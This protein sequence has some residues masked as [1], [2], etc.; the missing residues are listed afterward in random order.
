MPDFERIID[1]ARIH[2]APDDAMREWAKGY[3]AGKTRARM[4]VFAIALCF[5]IAL[6]GWF[7]AA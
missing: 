3:A 4:E 6:C 2:A 5:G 1:S 7:Y